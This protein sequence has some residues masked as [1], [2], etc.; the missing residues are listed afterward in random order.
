MSFLIDG[1]KTDIIDPKCV[2]AKRKPAEKGRARRVGSND[3][4]DVRLGAL[5]RNLDGRDRC[6]GFVLNL[7]NQPP[8]LG[9]ARGRRTKS[10]H[11]NQK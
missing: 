8:H 6:S 11:K 9:L 7:D 4:R 5:Q 1:V 2:S 10:S 3:L